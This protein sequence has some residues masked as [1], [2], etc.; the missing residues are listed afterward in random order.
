[1]KNTILYLI[2]I[3][4]F[5]NSCE[6]V[7]DKPKTV[8]EDPKPFV[9]TAL[10]V[11]NEN[12]GFSTIYDSAYQINKLNSGIS[13]TIG[14]SDFTI[15]NQN[16]LNA[17]YFTTRP[18]QQSTFKDFV[19]ISYDMS[20]SN[21]LRYKN[22]VDGKYFQFSDL[23][24]SI[25]GGGGGFGTPYW[26]SY[27]GDISAYFSTVNYTGVPD[28]GFRHPVSNSVEG[29]GYFGKLK[30]GTQTLNGS[31]FDMIKAGVLV[32]YKNMYKRSI[33]DVYNNVN[34]GISIRQDSIWVYEI[35]T[36]KNTLKTAIDIS[37]D[38]NYIIS[39]LIRKYSPDGKKLTFGLVYAINSTTTLIS[40]FSYNYETNTLEKYIKEANIPF[41]W[42]NVDMDIDE[43]GNIYFAGY[44]SNGTNTSGVSIYKCTSATNKELIGS[45]NFLKS[46]EVVGL[47]YL[48]G[49]V[50]LAVTAK[51]TDGNVHQI[52][53]LKQN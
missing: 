24:V 43:S 6:L 35:D 5:F 11:L 8:N 37:Y 9:P 41:Y 53:F 17:C 44:A 39:K 12:S 45:D 31:E 3:T 52:S 33:H 27:G 16:Q 21:L 22:G 18:T 25:S 46:G 7:E 2:F 36:I 38:K 13:G 15:E 29:F 34:Y 48:Y 26:V 19:R 23:L 4:I 51:H 49:K 28:L 47:K 30:Q 1:M 42:E 10:N 14:L 40:T 50:Y 20:S 32:D